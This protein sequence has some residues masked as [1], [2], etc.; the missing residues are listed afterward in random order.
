M[1]VVLWTFEGGVVKNKNHKK[2]KNENCGATVFL[3][4][5]LLCIFL[6]DALNDTYTYT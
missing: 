1:V 6:M 4:S 3:Y 2:V 5:V